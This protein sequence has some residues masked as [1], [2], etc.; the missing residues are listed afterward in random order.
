MNTRRNVFDLFA[1]ANCAFALTGAIYTHIMTPGATPLEGNA[2]GQMTMGFSYLAVAPILVTYR[3]EVLI[4]LRRNWSLAALVLLAFTSSLWTETPAF[5]ARRCFAVGCATFF[6]V[7][8]TVKLTLKEQLRLLS[9]LFR[10]ISILS[11]T[12]VFLLPSY[13]LTDSMEQEWRGAFGFKN[14]LGVVMALSALVE[15]QL[16]TNTRWSKVIN[17]AALLLSVF[18]LIRSDS[19]TP[20]VA[21]VGAFVLTEIYKLATLRMRMPL[22]A[23]A[24]ATLLIVSLGFV[25]VTPKSD[26]LAALVGR[27]PERAS[28][29]TGR[30]EIWRWVVSFIQERPILGYGYA[31]FW[32]ESAAAKIERALGLPMYSHNGYL[33]T[34]LTNGVLGL[35]L[36]LVF[37]GTGLKRAFD[38]SVQV[39]SRTSLWPLAFLSFFLFYNLGECTIFMQHTGWALCV[40]AVAGSDHALFAPETAPEDELVLTTSAEFN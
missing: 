21:L 28:D 10:I 20:L 24:V 37:L 2:F 3:R 17:R 18:L 26:A 6:G 34:L 39:T 11:L 22:Y 36:A 30:T 7:A 15:W 33:D 4:I 35:S 25:I 8:L 40:A 19:M 12:C 27:T 5:S 31:G 9:W 23:T 38:W 32:T 14:V 16:P 1:L 29:L 13:G